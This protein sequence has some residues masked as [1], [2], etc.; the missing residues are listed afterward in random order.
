VSNDCNQKHVPAG[1]SRREALKAGAALFATPLLSGVT[2]VLQAAEAASARLPV[3]R[4]G[5][6]HTGKLRVSTT[7][8]SNYSGDKAGS[9]Y[10][11][12]TQIDGENF[13]RLRVAWT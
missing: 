7:E 3:D 9:K 13:G 5:Q 6:A 1:L 12:L 11:P 8:W 10:S 2:S 4:P